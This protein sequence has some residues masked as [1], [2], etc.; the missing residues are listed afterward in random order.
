MIYRW[1]GNLIVY[2]MV[3]MAVSWGV[4]VSEGEGRKGWGST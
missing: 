3:C 4:M 2:M 1:I